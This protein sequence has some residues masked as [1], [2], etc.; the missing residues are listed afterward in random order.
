MNVGDVLSQ[1]EI[2]I[3]VGNIYEIAVEIKEEKR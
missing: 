2:M 1:A 3:S